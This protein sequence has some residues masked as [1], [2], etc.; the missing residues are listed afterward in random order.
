MCGICGVYGFNSRYIMKKMCDII[1]HRGPDDEGYYCDADVMLGMRRLKVI[2]LNTGNQPIYN[3]DKSIVIVYNGEIYNYKEIRDDLKR[4]GHFFKTNSDTEIIV[5]LYEEFEDNFVNKLRGMF[6]IALW[7]SKKRRLLLVRDRVGIKPLYYYFKNAI[8]AFASEIKSLLVYP[9][10]SRELN[11]N[12]LHNYLA[13]M[14]V[15]APQTIF[16]NIYKLLPGHLL[17]YE[18]GNLT[19]RQYWNI[20][21]RN[22]DYKEILRY[23]ENELSVQ[24]L[25]FMQESVRMHLISDV[26]LGVFLSGGTDSGSIVA[27]ASEISG[28]PVKSFSIGFED[29]YLNELDNAKLVTKKYKTDHHEF[30][31]KPPGI[32]FMENI[33]SSFDEPFADSSAIPTYLVSKCAREYVT[34]A[35]SGDGGD[36]VFGGYGNYKADK[37]GQYYRKLPYALRERIIPFFI[38]KLPGSQH[39]LSTSQ[40]LKKLLEMVKLSPECGHV[41]WLSVFNNDIKEKLYKDENLKVLLGVNS[42][43]YYGS[44]FE[45]FNGNDFINRCISVDIKT[46]LPDD[47]LTKVDRM[48]MANS[49]EVRVPFLDHKLLEFA[50]VIP[51]KFKLKG[52]NTKYLLKEVMKNRLPEEIINGKKKGFSIPLSRWFREDFSILIDKYLSEKLIRKRGYFN[53]HPVSMLSRE[54]LS[55]KKD[56]S[57]FLWALI[58]FEMWHRRFLD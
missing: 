57:K 23:D 32:D 13:Y 27:L 25:S 47:Y 52:L 4:K 28:R 26:P 14:Y 2:D 48:S 7:D 40:Q 9:E 58:C 45:K 33:I 8:L 30:V 1:A 54:H 21:N 3:E 36:E 51:S 31:V 49:L 34:V 37:I 50:A 16:K 43:D 35:L 55:G 5:H 17:V 46:V 53:Y 29:D 20:Y 18:K 22:L 42:I 44:Y 56:N 39:S 24:L 12:A 41:F 38:D 6:A 11:Y 15:P 10:I 19:V